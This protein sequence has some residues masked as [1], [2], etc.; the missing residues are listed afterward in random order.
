MIVLCLRFPVDV[1]L[2]Y[3]SCQ[4][5]CLPD[6]EANSMTNAITRLAFKSRPRFKEWPSLRVDVTCWCDVVPRSGWADLI[7]DCLGWCKL[8][9]ILHGARCRI[10]KFELQTMQWDVIDK[11]PWS[12]FQGCTLML[13]WFMICVDFQDSSISYTVIYYIHYL[14]SSHLWYIMQFQNIM[15]VFYLS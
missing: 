3:F 5:L 14:F 9:T 7:R 12:W 4:T 6:I 8:V 10:Q 15:I 13:S 1:L 2:C 11:L